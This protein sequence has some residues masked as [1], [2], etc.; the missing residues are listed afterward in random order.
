MAG[1]QKWD[2]SI[3]NTLIQLLKNQ[4]ILQAKVTDLEG[5]SRR[6]NIR[7]YAVPENTEGT[8]TSCFI[9]DFIIRE[10]GDN[11]GPSL[12]KELGIERAHRALAPKP[13]PGVSPRS[14]VV[15]FLQFTTKEKVQQAAWKK[16]MYAQE[17][18]V[19]F[20]HDYAEQVQQIRKEY[21][22]VMRV[23]KENKIQFQTPL[24]RMRVHLDSGTVTYNTASEAAEDLSK[25]GFSVGRIRGSKAEGITEETLTKLLPWGIAGEH[26]TGSKSNFQE[27][28]REKLKGFG[29]G[30]RDNEAGEL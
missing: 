15:R 2:V 18:R 8:S 7:I 6:N 25:R 4:E 30:N 14:I 20:D 12:G 21:A 11:L 5:R 17:K 24:T 29:R 10:L 27:A 23:L 3:K 28:V 19:Y 16:M 26:G 13:Q 9:E 1:S 22:P